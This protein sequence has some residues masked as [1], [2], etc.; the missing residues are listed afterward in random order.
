[1]ALA[2]AIRAGVRTVHADVRGWR[3]S[4][5]GF[6][7]GTV[8]DALARWHR[9]YFWLRIAMIVLEIRGELPVCQFHPFPL[10]F[11][12]FVWVE[13][14]LRRTNFVGGTESHPIAHWVVH[15]VVRGSRCVLVRGSRWAGAMF[16]FSNNP[17]IFGTALRSRAHLA[18]PWF[19]LLARKTFALELFRL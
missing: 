17:N 11:E 14:T 12:V 7:V 2:C 13:H 8:H 5:L 6:L 16:V 9:N 4:A 15:A 18:K 10:R 19:K 3:W 1:M